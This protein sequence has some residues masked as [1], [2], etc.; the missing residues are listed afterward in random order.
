MQH[1][2]GVLLVHAQAVDGHHRHAVLVAELLRELLYGTGFGVHR[3][4]QD[5]E[6]LAQRFQFLDDPLLR[7]HV[8]LARQ[9]RDGAVGRHHDPDGG[10]L[11]D[12]LAGA[13]LGRFLEGDVPLKPRRA[14][15]ARPL[16][17]LIAPR[18]G[19]GVT[20][21]V[22]QPDAGPRPVELQLDRL[23]GDKQGLGGHDGAPGTAL[24]ELVLGPLAV[25]AV[26]DPGEDQEVHE[27]LD[28]G[29]L[30][31][32]HRADDPD[33]DAASGSLGDVAEEVELFQ[34]GV[35]PSRWRNCRAGQYNSYSRS[36][37]NITAGKA[38][39]SKVQKAT[40]AA[41]KRRP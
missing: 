38:P 13:D 7:F 40:S 19:Y 8:G 17:V 18:A 23:I 3:V 41:C 25:V 28:E 35:P 27:A 12:H 1:V 4:E 22:D 9:V 16:L 33:V 39:L 31:G 36:G 34:C 32:A 30:S 37:G 21:A 5:E 10:V 29:R 6:R 11:L 15:Q 20:D 24:R 2:Q 14:H 26:L